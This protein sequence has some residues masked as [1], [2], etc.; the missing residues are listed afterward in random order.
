MDSLDM[1]E[2]VKFDE[3][4]S[5]YQLHSHQ[6]Y[7]SQKFDYSDEIRITVQDQ[8]LLTL[9]SESLLYIE[10]TYSITD[11]KAGYAFTYNF[12]AFL[13]SEIRYEMNGQILDSSMNPGLTSFMKGMLSYGSNESK[14]LA[15]AGWPYLSSVQNINKAKKH[16]V[17]LIPLKHLLGFA[18]D[19]R[20]VIPNARHDLILIRARNNVNCYVCP[21]TEIKINILKLH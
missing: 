20:K 21:S 2:N 6:P 3:R 19:C 7:G 5:K 17:A 8:N 1:Y 14:A 4:V 10:G 16:F 12:P 15:G 18:E 13:F 11:D 9:P